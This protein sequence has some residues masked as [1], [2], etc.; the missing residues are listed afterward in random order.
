V[1][2]TFDFVTESSKG[3]LFGEMIDYDGE[4]SKLDY[5]P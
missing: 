2:P 1:I 3:V 4:V 5:V